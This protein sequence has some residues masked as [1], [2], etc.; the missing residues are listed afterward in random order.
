MLSQISCGGIY[1]SKCLDW[2]DPSSTPRESLETGLM[3]IRRIY[4]R[5]DQN[6]A[7]VEGGQ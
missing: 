7:E 2:L 1:N 4:G 3:E 6:S 5:V